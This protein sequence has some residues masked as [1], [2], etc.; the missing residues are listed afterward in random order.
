VKRSVAREEARTPQALS[1]EEKPRA[2]T[3]AYNCPIDLPC[4]SSN[5]LA[6]PW[7]CDCR[8]GKKGAHPKLRYPFAT[9]RKLLKSRVLNRRT[10]THTTPSP[11]CS[12]SGNSTPQPQVV[13]PPHTHNNNN[14]KLHKCSREMGGRRE[15]EGMGDDDS[16]AMRYAMLLGGV[17]LGWRER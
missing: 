8:S 7:T 1:V 17:S 4:P 11:A 10:Q 2:N 12:T 15:G 16:V 5:G 13:T 3:A 6:F 9:P 14:S